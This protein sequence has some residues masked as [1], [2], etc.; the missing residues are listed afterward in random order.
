MNRP[1]TM[2]KLERLNIAHSVNV[3]MFIFKLRVNLFEYISYQSYSQCWSDALNGDRFLVVCM[4]NF[5]HFFILFVIRT[6]SILLN[7]RKTIT[8]TRRCTIPGCETPTDSLRDVKIAERLRALKIKKVFIPKRARVCK[9]HCSEHSWNLDIPEHM[10]FT[11]KQLV[12]LITLFT[13]LTKEITT[14]GKCLLQLTTQFPW[15]SIHSLQRLLFS[16]KWLA[17]SHKTILV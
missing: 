14:T 17:F 1:V 13:E 5:I 11:P 9:L 7:F 8:S 6:A 10:N 4:L 3:K 16:F 15:F 2:C 12:E